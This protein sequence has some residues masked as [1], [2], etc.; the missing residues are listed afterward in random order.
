[1]QEVLTQTI[2]S[3]TTTKLLFLRLVVVSSGHERKN[4][5]ENMAKISK[6]KL[7][8]LYVVAYSKDMD[9]AQCALKVYKYL[10]ERR[11][12]LI[13]GEEQGVICTRNDVAREL[14]LNS[15]Q[16][17]HAF[18]ALRDLRLVSKHYIDGRPVYYK[19]VSPD[20]VLN[21]A[22]VVFSKEISEWR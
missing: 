2:L 18:K 11:R 8:I 3:R 16:T 4:M 7:A 19:V 5:Q 20:E 12:E 15:K 14:R 9:M 10:A 1:M 22:G 13:P 21:V 6:S 17:F